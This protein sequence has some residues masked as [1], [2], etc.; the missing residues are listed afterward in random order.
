MDLSGFNIGFNCKGTEAR[1]RLSQKLRSIISNHVETTSLNPTNG[2]TLVE[3]LVC[4]GMS[5][6]LLLVVLSM[7][8]SSLQSQKKQERITEV[9]QQ[10]AMVMELI[11]QTLR[12][13]EAINSP[14][15]GTSAS[16]L[17]IDVVDV[18]DDPTVFTISGGQMNVT[19]G[20]GL[21]V[22]L[23]STLLNA[24]VIT[25]TNVTSSG[26]SGVMKIEFTLSLDSYEQTFYGTA[27][28]RSS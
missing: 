13:A 8:L 24:S 7:F 17:S 25:F 14:V 20:A 27:T 22:N 10:G 4:L 1:R 5:A 26:S 23:T 9:E 2:F 12:N 15:T 21:P 28:L 11:T 18:S 19:R 16:S 6:M 3:L